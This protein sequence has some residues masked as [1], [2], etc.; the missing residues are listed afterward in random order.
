MDPVV[1]TAL[2]AAATAAATSGATKVVEKA[3]MDAYGALKEKIKSKFGGKS[4][5]AEA[6]EKLDAKP[7]SKARQDAV[8]EEV[9]SVKGEEDEELRALAQALLAAM[10]SSES[11]KAALGKFNV[12]AKGAQIGV[13]GDHTRVEG[14]IHFGSKSGSA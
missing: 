9:E 6:V 10:Q 3:F 4:D 12:D 13:I 8:K 7:E 11:G 2:W 14:G 1:T 5:L